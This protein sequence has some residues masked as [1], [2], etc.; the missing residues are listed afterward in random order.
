MAGC[1]DEGCQFFGEYRYCA[2]FGDG[3][4]AWAGLLTDIEHSH[5]VVVKG[6][7]WWG[8]PLTARVIHESD[9]IGGSVG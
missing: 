6:N 9:F 7:V 2:I 4:Y 5:F 8:E 3:L 1:V